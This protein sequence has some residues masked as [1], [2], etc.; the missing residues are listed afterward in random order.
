MSGMQESGVG[1]LYPVGRLEQS[2]VDNTSSRVAL[3]GV[4]QHL[5]QGRRNE[6]RA[7]LLRSPPPEAA[8]HLKP[9]ADGPT[10][11]V[12]AP[13]NRGGSEIDLGNRDRVVDLPHR[14]PESGQAVDH[15]PLRGQTSS[16]RQ[17]R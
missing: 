14:P 11:D 12:I 4:R 3:R 13:N 8:C 15:P 7:N 1:I 6:R 5:F 2:A 9:V 10:A 16:L 17:I